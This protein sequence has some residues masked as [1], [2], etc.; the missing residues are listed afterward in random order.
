MAVVGAP[1][2][3]GVCARIFMS[4]PALHTC[5]CVNVFVKLRQLTTDSRS[6]FELDAILFQ[7]RVRVVRHCE[8]FKTKTDYK[9]GEYIFNVNFSKFTSETYHSFRRLYQVVQMII[10]SF[11][12]HFIKSCCLVGRISR[13]IFIHLSI[14]V[15]SSLIFIQPNH[16][17]VI[18]PY[19]NMPSSRF[20]FVAKPTVSQ[21]VK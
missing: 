20:N 7:E 1:V 18:Q 8:T 9:F 6:L 5:V 21:I 4:A 17:L 2:L 19:D 14:Y 16:K 13:S 3:D 15:W 10:K 12:S 11:Q